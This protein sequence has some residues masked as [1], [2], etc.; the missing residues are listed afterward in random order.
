[1]LTISRGQTVINKTLQL[2]GAHSIEM[3]FDYP[4]LIK[5][6]TWSKNEISIQGVV[7]INDGEND[8]A[9]SIESS[10]TGSTIT[11]QSLIKDFEALP[12]HITI[13]NG[14]EKI[15]FKSKAELTKFQQE[16]SIAYNQMSYGIDMEI[17]LEIKVPIDMETEIKSVYG[18]VEINNFAGP[19]SVEATYGGVDAALNEKLTGEL[20]AETNYGEILT[21]LT[22][23]FA[24]ENDRH[25][26][27]HTYVTAKPGAGPR[28][29]FESKYGNVYLRKSQ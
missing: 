7:N 21:N 23:R 20:V 2:Q 12:R 19:L 5:I 3:H 17:Q 10:V 29:S 27:F 15:I 25:E 14:N 18:M 8:N 13:Q 4:K 22:A 28:Y 9:F 24:S 6:T 1:M 26:D 11:V 16:H